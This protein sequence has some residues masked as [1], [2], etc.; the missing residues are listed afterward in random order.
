MPTCC[1]S[2]ISAAMERQRALASTWPRASRSLARAVALGQASLPYAATMYSAA[3]TVSGWATMTKEAPLYGPRYVQ[4][5]I[6]WHPVFVEIAA[7]AVIPTPEFKGAT[8]AQP[9]DGNPALSK[10]LGV[11]CRYDVFLSRD[12]PTWGQDIALIA[13]HH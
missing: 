4:P 1:S 5:E 8:V 10:R 11:I 2:A 13:R 6:Q 3:R 9:T 7:D 12:A